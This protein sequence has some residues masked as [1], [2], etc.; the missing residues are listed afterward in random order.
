MLFL[1]C[2]GKNTSELQQS[3]ILTKDAAKK[4]ANDLEL[5][6]S[7]VSEKAK[8]LMLDLQNRINIILNLKRRKET[9]NG[10]ETEF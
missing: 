6:G 1:G 7:E 4:L 10:T 2:N 8:K 5:D 3:I 9:E